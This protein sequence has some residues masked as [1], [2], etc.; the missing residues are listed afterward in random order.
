MINTGA[1]RD[2]SRS[3][4][5]NALKEH[6]QMYLQNIPAYVYYIRHKPTGKFY[7]GSRYNH[8]THNLFPA[9]DLWHTYFTS[10]KEI[11]RLRKETGNDSFEYQIIFTD[12]D[13]DKCFEY[14]QNLI[15]E[16]I[17]DPLCVNKRYFDSI[18]GTKVFSTFGKTLS[19]KGKPKS[20]ETKQ[21]MRKPKSAEHR[22]TMSERQKQ[23]GGNGPATHTAESKNKIKE[24]MILL[25]RENKV[26]PHCNKEGGFLSMSRWHFDNC[27]LKERL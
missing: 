22:Q 13:T 17:K 9:Q 1:N 8:V 11:A 21:R 25:P 16:N 2:P 14:E 10:S 12:K 24:A 20:E 27:K 5:T 7:Y 19:S 4:G 23:N 3:I 26:C 18:N 15:K 6:Q